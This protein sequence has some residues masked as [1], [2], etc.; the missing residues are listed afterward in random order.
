MTERELWRTADRAR[1]FLLPA[2]SEGPPGN[3]GLRSVDGREARVHQAWARQY[4]VSEAEGRAFAKAELG[5]TLDELRGGIDGL[6]ARLRERID[7]AKRTPVAE[8]SAVTPD[9]VPALFELLRALPGLIG[10]GLSGDAERTERAKTAA[11][12]LEER[13]K[14]AGIDVGDRLAAFPGRLERLRSEV[15]RKDPS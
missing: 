11:A 8:G 6:L 4:E 7:E 12:A 3:L 9:A 2:Q 10:N 14:A 1:W 5:E 13:L 15:G